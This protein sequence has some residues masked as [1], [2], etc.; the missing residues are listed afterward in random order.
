MGRF[1]YGLVN[2][3]IP[4]AVAVIKITKKKGENEKVKGKRKWGWVI[5]TADAK[6]DP[7]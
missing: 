3:F 2:C 7:G 5:E 6:S 4:F 1:V